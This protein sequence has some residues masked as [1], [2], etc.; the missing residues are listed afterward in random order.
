M[1]VCVSGGERHGEEARVAMAAEP[2]LDVEVKLMEEERVLEPELTFLAQGEWIVT[3]NFDN[4]S[5]K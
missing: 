1:C 2:K 4:P 3:T 5:T